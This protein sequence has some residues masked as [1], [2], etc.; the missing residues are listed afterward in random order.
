MFQGKALFTLENKEKGTHIT[1]KVKSPKKKR[2]QPE[3]TRYFDIEVKALNDG[4]HGMRYIGRLD[5]KLKQLKMSG[6]VEKDHVGVQT[7]QWIMKNWKNLEKFEED[8]KLGM[9]HL[10]ICCKCGMPLTVP[11]SIENGI[12]PHCKKYREGRSIKLMEELGISIA[13]FKKYEDMVIHACEQRPD[14]VEKIFIPDSVRR[15]SSWVQMLES[16]SDFGLF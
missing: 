11:D 1:F 3:D 16:V 14:I 5:R 2:D 9:Y 15:E 13:G 10:G 8:G 7:L 4:W 6:K 12:G